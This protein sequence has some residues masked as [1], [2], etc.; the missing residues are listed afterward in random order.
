VNYFDSYTL[1]FKGQPSPIQI[2]EINYFIDQEGIEEEAIC[3][4]FTKAAEAGAKY[5]YA[6]SILNS[7]VSKGIKTVQDVEEENIA[8]EQSRKS[9]SNQ[10]SCPPRN[11]P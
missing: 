6:R 3:I 2:Q 8:Y 9:F 5:S 7:W 10:R 11:T 4:T 1:C